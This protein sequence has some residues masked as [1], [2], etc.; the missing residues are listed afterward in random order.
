MYDA[1]ETVAM[2][3]MTRNFNY[4]SSGMILQDAFSREV[5]ETV[6][7]QMEDQVEMLLFHI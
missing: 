2:E 5:L 7:Q 4:R 3:W 1:F 6:I